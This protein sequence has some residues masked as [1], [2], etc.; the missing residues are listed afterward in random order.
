VAVYKSQDP[1]GFYRNQ[2]SVWG[3]QPYKGHVFFS[4]MNSGLWAVRLQPRSRPIS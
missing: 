3:P 4:D 1:D 2:V